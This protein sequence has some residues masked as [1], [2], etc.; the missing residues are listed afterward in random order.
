MWVTREN[1]YHLSI[2]MRNLKSQVAKLVQ[3]FINMLAILC[4]SEGNYFS[5][6]HRG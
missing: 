2:A 1:M 5:K 4:F 6:I 3:K